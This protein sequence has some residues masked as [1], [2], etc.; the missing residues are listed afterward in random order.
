MKSR[1]KI[2]EKILRLMKEMLGKGILKNK[3]QFADKLASYPTKISKIEKG[4]CMFSLGMLIQFFENFGEFMSP[5]QLFDFDD[6]QDNISFLIDANAGNSISTKQ[7][8][9]DIKFR[10]PDLFDDGYK[11]FRIRGDSMIPTLNNDDILVCEKVLN[12][13]NIKNNK[14]YVISSNDGVNVKRLKLT[15]KENIITGIVLLSDNPNGY[16]PM[17]VDFSEGVNYLPFIDI[18]K[19]VRRITENG[20]I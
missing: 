16:P 9:S 12:Q 4:E 7:D 10:L 18:Y 5:N 2:D 6:L 14:I 17:K 1:K 11:A 8:N 15:K 13:S 3:S 20:I 19:P